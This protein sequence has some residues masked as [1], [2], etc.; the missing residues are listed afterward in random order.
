M[1]N[2]GTEKASSVATIESAQQKQSAD[3]ISSMAH[4]LSGRL[5][6]PAEE[7][8][9]ILGDNAATSAILERSLVCF[10]GRKKQTVHPEDRCGTAS[11]A[12]H[13]WCQPM[14][15]A[16]RGEVLSLSKGA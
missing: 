7:L 12:G 10:P 14:K 15:W 4:A 13:L 3:R 6:H 8:G 9:R 5:I 1:R 2:V 11:L 16:S